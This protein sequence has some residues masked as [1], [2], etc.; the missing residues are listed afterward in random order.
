MAKQKWEIVEFWSLEIRK[1]MAALSITSYQLH[2][3]EAS[4][5]PDNHLAKSNPAAANVYL[6]KIEACKKSTYFDWKA[7]YI[8][9]LKKKLFPPRALEAEQELRPPIIVGHTCRNT[10]G[11]TCACFARQWDASSKTPARNIQ[12]PST[13]LHDT[14]QMDIIHQNIGT[15]KPHSIQPPAAHAKWNHTM[16]CGF[17]QTTLQH[18]ISTSM[19]SIYWD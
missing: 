4:L 9:C 17:T 12:T 5:T 13:Y 14:S 18:K 1:P 7:R 11:R 16:K 15:L 6:S 19:H 3:R 10:L 8:V 2:L